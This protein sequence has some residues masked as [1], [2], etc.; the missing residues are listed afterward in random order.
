MIALSVA[1][2]FAAVAERTIS[3]SYTLTAD[4]DWTGDG[5]VTLDSAT[6]DLAGYS[7]KVHGLTGSGTIVS[8]A[9]LTTPEGEIGS[10]GGFSDSS[11]KLLFD[12]DINTVAYRGATSGNSLIVSYEFKS[13]TRIN[14]YRLYA[15]APV[16]NFGFPKD[17]T[18]E[19]S[20][21]NSTWT[22]LDSR[23]EQVLVNQAWHSFAFRNDAEY[24]YYR[25]KVTKGSRRNETTGKDP[26][27]DFGG[28]LEMGLATGK[29]CVDVTGLHGSD[30]S[31]IDIADDVSVETFGDSLT[32]DG[33]LDMRGFPVSA[34][35][36]LNGHTLTVSSL[37]GG[38][39]ITDSSHAEFVDL[40]SSDGEISSTGG[41]SDSYPVNSLFDDNTATFSLRGSTSSEPIAVCYGF[42]EATC[43]NRY[44]IYAT[45]SVGNPGFPKDW[46]LEGSNDKV[47]WNVLDVRTG[48]VM[49]NGNWYTYDIG[50][51]VA[52]KYYRMRV[53]KGS[54]WDET[55]GNDPRIDFGGELDLGYRPKAGQVVITVPVGK[56]VENRDVTLSGNVRLIK[57]GEGAFV[58]SKVSQAYLGGTEVRNGILKCGSEGIGFFGADIFPIVIR[59]TATLDLAGMRRND[60]IGRH[61]V[62]LDGGT[63]ANSVSVGGSVDYASPMRIS[64]TSDSF[65]H[66]NDNTFI[67]TETSGLGAFLDLGGYELSCSIMNGKLFRLN[68]ITMMNG[69]FSVD[70]PTTGLIFIGY[71][72]G[73]V[74]T[75]VDFKLNC[76]VLVRSNCSFKVRD[77][78]S[79]GGA[80]HTYSQY[81]PMEVY[82]AFTPT[83][84]SFYGCTL[85]DGATLDLST[86]VTALNAVS[87]SKGGLT[88]LAFRADATVKVKL[89]T[90]RFAQSKILSWTADTKPANID[91]VEFVKAD[92][93]RRYSL[94]LKD[95][96]LYANAGLVIS[97]H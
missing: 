76:P 31:A 43:V 53:T 96:G 38:G 17:W 26:R 51:D 11:A 79:L 24:L 35:I 64:L 7:L 70:E 2:P 86:R 28:E 66:A 58:A 9:D 41:L 10:E 95:D 5:I 69:R 48:M 27:I 91:T 73:V 1:L 55:K 21:D 63:L 6:I 83:S 87:A 45:T 88:N 82:G 23:T 75:N 47:T 44:R 65:A 68:N 59:D 36:D 72:E 50:N 56:T 12:N 77:Y 37:S 19:G 34:T 81:G 52:Y 30:I 15:A 93:D 3:G 39:T 92:A 16:S 46:T 42:N 40:T 90:K 20:N 4:E 71:G 49:S 80:D 25:M 78:E 94:L 32:L 14:Y 33:D 74:A 29:V 54:R 89:G 62:I 18:F 84:D 60:T 61:T 67:G 8:F 57:E 13:A 85:M 97:I 22:E